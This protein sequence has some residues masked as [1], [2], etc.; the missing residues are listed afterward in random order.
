MTL[1]EGADYFIHIVQFP[2]GFR[3]DGLVTPNDDGTFSVYLDANKTK[4]RQRMACD[5][6]LTHIKNDDF[7][8]GKPIEAVESA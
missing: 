3:C 2:K 6:E 4:E 7:Y 1:I 5:H 8:N